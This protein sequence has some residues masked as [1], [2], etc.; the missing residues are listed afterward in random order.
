MFWPNVLICPE[1]TCWKWLG[2]LNGKGYVNI[3]FKDKN[4]KG[5]HVSLLLHGI[6]RPKNTEVD[7][8]CR[9]RDCVNPR[10]LRS[11]THRINMIENSISASALN[12]KKTHCKH[13]HALVEENIIIRIRPNGNRNRRCKACVRLQY[14]K[15]MVEKPSL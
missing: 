7:H 4:Y 11:V 12:F 6:R 8:I 5:H 14:H 1:L 15:I 9:N 13:G 2:G 3:R 10:H